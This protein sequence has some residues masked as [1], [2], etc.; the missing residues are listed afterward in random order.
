M[1]LLDWRAWLNAMVWWIA[2]ATAVNV[3]IEYGF[4]WGTFGV[5]LPSAIAMMQGYG[6]GHKA[7]LDWANDQFDK[8]I[9]DLEEE[10]SDLRGKVK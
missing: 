8:D 2:S 3:S 4:W 6:D 9:E 10:L 1:I 7:A 5:I